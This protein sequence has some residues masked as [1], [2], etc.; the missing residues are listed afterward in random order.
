MEDQVPRRQVELVVQRFDRIRRTLGGVA[1]QVDDLAR[2]GEGA[3]KSLSLSLERSGG[4][5]RREVVEDRLE[6]EVD[7][8][9]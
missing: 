3:T 6:R 9:E 8:S 7:V 2:F 5:L 1:G 4:A